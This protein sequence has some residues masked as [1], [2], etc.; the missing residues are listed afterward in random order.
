M[1]L[2]VSDTKEAVHDVAYCG[3][4]CAT[5]P[6]H[7]GEIAD[8]ARDLRKKLREYRFKR[9]AHA[10]SGPFDNYAQCYETLGAMVKLRCKR[11]CRDNGGP[12]QCAIR[13][14]ARKRDFLGCWDCKDFETCDKFNFL[15]P[16]HG[17]ANVKNLKTIQKHGV[18]A[19]LK[20]K[21]YW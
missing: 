18:D 12:P 20:G 13:N 17:D 16:V 8:L 4:C 10:F 21:I 6:N 1:N 9:I 5:C 14:C 11:G 19:F 2:D 3:L 7:T 15:K